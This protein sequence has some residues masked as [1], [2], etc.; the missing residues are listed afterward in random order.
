[1]PIPIKI[2]K[3]NHKILGVFF[4]GINAYI[5]M[6][7]TIKI[8]TL[9]PDDVELPWWIIALPMITISPFSN[10]SAGLGTADNFF[11]VTDAK[12]ENI[13]DVKII[14]KILGAYTIKM[15]NRGNKINAS[16]SCVILYW[17]EL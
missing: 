15:L 10:I 3:R 7:V 2:I 14:S 12:S 11:S 13:P 17:K 8:I 16:P 9:C 1:M 4:L 6:L 5:R